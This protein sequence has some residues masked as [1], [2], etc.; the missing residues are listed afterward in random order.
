LIIEKKLNLKM[1]LII[2]EVKLLEKF[3]VTKNV[4]IRWLTFV[5]HHLILFNIIS[6]N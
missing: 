6:N 1:S 3:Y 2:H 5:F 4:I